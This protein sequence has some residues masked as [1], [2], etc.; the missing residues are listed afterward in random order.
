MQA[1]ILASHIYISYIGF[2]FD[3]A[4]RITNPLQ[5]A[6]LLFLSKKPKREE[7]ERPGNFYLTFYTLCLYCFCRY[8]TERISLSHPKPKSKKKEEN[9]LKNLGHL[10]W[11]IEQN[12][13]HRRVCDRFNYSE[14]DF[15]MFCSLFVL[16]IP[17]RFY[18]YLF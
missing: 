12:I 10:R 11:I 15:H 9:S 2:W 7:M 14:T 17:P 1:R 18:K 6:S 13:Y 5:I 4:Y 3:E 16:L 8:E